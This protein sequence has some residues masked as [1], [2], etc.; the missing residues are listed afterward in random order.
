VNTLIG[1]LPQPLLGQLIEMRQGFELPVTG[2]EVFLDI[3]HHA[4]VL[5][6]V[7]SC[8][9]QMMRLM[10]LEFGFGLLIRFIRFETSHSVS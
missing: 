9:M 6:F 8:R 4:L 10:R 3:A 2:E 7:Q 1:F 5:A